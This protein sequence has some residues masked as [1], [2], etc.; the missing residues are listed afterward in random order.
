MVAGFS[1]ELPERNKQ[2][3]N[4]D[5]NNNDYLNKTPVH[6]FFKADR[7]GI[8]R[9]ARNNLLFCRELTGSRHGRP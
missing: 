1:S 7:Y 9:I 8:G 4:H 2:D 3:Q 5:D 6:G